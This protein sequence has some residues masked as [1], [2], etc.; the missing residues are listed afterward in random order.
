MSEWIFVLLCF[1]FL[2]LIVRTHSSL[3]LNVRVCY[4]NGVNKSLLKYDHIAKIWTLRISSINSE[5]YTLHTINDNGIDFTRMKPIFEKGYYQC[6]HLKTFL[7]KTFYIF[8][9]CFFSEFVYFLLFFR[10]YEGHNRNK[11][12]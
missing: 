3:I 4:F 1:S 8:G 7:F 2:L 5:S 12:H 9:I 11:S 10:S 6:W